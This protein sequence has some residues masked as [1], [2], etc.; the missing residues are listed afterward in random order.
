MMGAHAQNRAYEVTR[1]S[2]NGS[3]VFRGVLTLDDL[4]NEPTFEW[5]K[6]GVTAYQPNAQYLD[7]LSHHLPDYKIVV[8]L[9][10]WCDDSHYWIPKLIRLLQAVNYPMGQLSL[11]GVDRTK[12]TLHGEQASYGITLVPAIILIKDG[13]EAGRIT[14]SAQNGLEA[15]LQK[16][17]QP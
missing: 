13:K 6:T 17:I 5:M 14:E 10:T 12:T 3:Q 1:D 7:F 11:Y 15:D 16:I 4:N 8:F 9:G 2:A